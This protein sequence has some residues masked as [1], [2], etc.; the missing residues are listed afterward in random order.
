TSAT[1]FL[2]THWPVSSK[3]GIVGELGADGYL[4]T[5]VNS[6][7]AFLAVVPDTSRFREYDFGIGAGARAQLQLR[8]FGRRFAEAAYRM[9]YSNTLNGSTGTLEGIGEV[10][11]WHILQALRIG[12]YSPRYKNFGVGADFFWYRRDSHF[13]RPELMEV[14]QKVRELRAFVTWEVGRGIGSN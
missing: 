10:D 8:L 1:L 13:N 12:L 9:A 11:T 7:L 4:M 3:F 2:A 6:E 5:A 14:T